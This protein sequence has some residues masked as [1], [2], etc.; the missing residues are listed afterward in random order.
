MSKSAFAVK[1]AR[2]KP[3]RQPINLCGSCGTEISASELLCREC[4]HT[5]NPPEEPAT[6]EAP[7]AAGRPVAFAWADDILRYAG[8]S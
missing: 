3:T 4:R 7:G 1:E 6:N 2:V 5:L 8:R